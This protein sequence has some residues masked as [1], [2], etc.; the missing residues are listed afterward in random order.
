MKKIIA[1]ILALVI[2]AP[3]LTT[4]SF[5]QANAHSEGEAHGIEMGT[6]QGEQAARND[7]INGLVQNDK[8][9]E[10]TNVQIINRFDLGRTD[11]TYRMFFMRGYRSAFRESYNTTY[12]QMNQQHHL[13]PIQNGFAHGRQIG[14]VEGAIF[15]LKDFMNQLNPNWF[16]AYNR[17]IMNGS[18]ES[19]FWLNRESELY[20]EHFEMGFKEGFKEN[21]LEMYQNSNIDAAMKNIHF[22]TIGLYADE[23][24]FSDEYIHFNHGSQGQTEHMSM[25]LSFDQGTVYTPTMIGMYRTQQR[26]GQGEFRMKPVSYRHHVSIENTLKQVFLEEPVTLGFQYNGSEYVGIYQWRNNRW[27]YLHTKMEEGFVYTTLPAGMYTGGEYAIF[28]DERAKDITFNRRH[29]AREEIYTLMRRE[30]LPRDGSFKAD[31]AVTR[32]DFA[33]M[34]YEIINPS[35]ARVAQVEIKDQDLLGKNKVAVN[36]MLARG[37][38]ELQDGNFNPNAPV[39]Y[40]DFE[41]AISRLLSRPFD[42]SEISTPMMHEKYRRSPSLQD[43][44]QGIPGGEMAFALIRLFR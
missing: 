39:T 26:F 41:R 44:N 29:W 33:Q 43:M 42:Y 36:E 1:W 19:R 16:F 3:N 18:L 30:V 25:V 11:Y 12:R 14:E 32:G 21:Y 17:Y 31:A 8:R 13:E 23:I 20:R 15:A 28:V 24:V 7:Y 34:L 40:R 4:V 9:H 27:E 35:T 6:L 38:F 22:K 5:A 10:L 37:V 2:V